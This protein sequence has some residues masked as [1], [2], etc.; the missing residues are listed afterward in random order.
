MVGLIEAYVITP[1]SVTWRYAGDVRILAASGYALVLQVAH[2]TVAAGVR[3]HSNYADDPW[4]RLLRTL[5]YA[6]VMVYGG[7]EAAAATGS[8]LREMHSQIRDT[9]PDGRSYSALEP[10]AWAWVHATLVEAIVAGHRRFG[11]RLDGCQVEELYAEWRAIGRLVGV[12]DQ[13]LPADW[14]GFRTYLEAMVERRLDDNDVVQGVLSSLARPAPPPIPLLTD[15]A[16]RAGR[17]PIARLFSLATAGLL[18]PVLRERCG[19]RW[20]RAQEL[21]LGALG[22]AVRSLTPIMPAYLANVGPGYLRWRR[23]AIAQG[24]LGPRKVDAPIAA[25]A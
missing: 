18:P 1:D 8:R 7:A 9:A 5:D 4:G 15:W 22:A 21:E 25:G 12:R 13:D 19:L 17:I 2:P 23:D 11:C 20:G 24:H 6:N 14:G 3:E 10:E 16:W